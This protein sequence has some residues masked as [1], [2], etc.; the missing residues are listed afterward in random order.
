MSDGR[1]DGFE[2]LVTAVLRGD[3]GAADRLLRF[4]TVHATDP[5]PLR[6]RAEAQLAAT[7]DEFDDLLRQI[8]EGAGDHVG[9][10]ADQLLANRA[11]WWRLLHVAR[12]VRRQR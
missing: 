4:M 6:Q 2:A 12:K 8:R 1:D 7:S 10:R 5:G 11:G 9:T 3:P